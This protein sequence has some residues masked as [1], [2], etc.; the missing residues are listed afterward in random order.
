M[1]TATVR[2]KAAFPNEDDALFPNQF[3]NARLLVDTKRN[4]VIVPAAAIQR[5]PDATFVYVVKPDSTVETRNVVSSLTESDQSAIDKGLEPGEMVVTDG[6]DKLQPGMK[7]RATESGAP[8]G[9][10]KHPSVHP[11]SAKTKG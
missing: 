4:V 8:P 1:T 6:V 7:V 10:P 11:A 2:F 5:S 3:V 9:G